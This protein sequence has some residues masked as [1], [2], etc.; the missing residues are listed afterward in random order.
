MTRLVESFGARG[1][2]QADGLDAVG[3]TPVQHDKPIAVEM[4]LGKKEALYWEK[5]PEKVRR[6]A[7]DKVVKA[8]S[9]SSTSPATDAQATRQS[10]QKKRT[11]EP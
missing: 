1:I 8:S 11:R 10:G 7:V 4:V 3:R 9:E 5:V 2:V 6:Q